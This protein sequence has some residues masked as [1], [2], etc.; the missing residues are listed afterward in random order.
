MNKLEQ[1]LTRIDLNLLIALSVLINE[2][3]VSKAAD[4][5]YVTQ[6]AMSKT[7]NRLRELFDDPLFHRTS[8][9]L[10]PN[11]K[12]LELEQKLPSILNQV[13]GLLLP[14]RFE[15]ETC[16]Q[17]FTI[18]V[19]SVLCHS[20]LLPFVLKVNKVAPNICI[21]DSPSEADPFPSL[22]QGRYDFAI[23]VTKPKS[24]QFGC[25]SLGLLKP[26]IFARKSHPLVKTKRTNSL[27]DLRDFSFVDYQVSLEE[28]KGFENPADRILRLFKFRPNVVCKSSHLSMITALLENSD[29]LLIAPSF[30]TNSIDFSNKFSS[31]YEFDTTKDQMLELLLLESPIVKNSDAEQWIKNELIKSINFD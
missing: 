11:A 3:S 31:V 7:L 26:N 5:L 10:V 23:H 24:S 13:N 16:E 17:T 29:C 8:S 19:P 1:K 18:S 14:K 6:P 27:D 22:E 15:P 25:T 2:K 21:V 20:I 28:K 9:G 4:A 30:M 12:A